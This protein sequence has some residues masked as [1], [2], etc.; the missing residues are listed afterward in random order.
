[1]SAFE[2]VAKFV[3]AVNQLPYYGGDKLEKVVEELFI[4]HNIQDGNNLFTSRFEKPQTRTKGE[5][6][7]LRAHVRREL[8][9]GNFKILADTIPEFKEGLWF[10]NQPMGDGVAYP[11]HLVVLYGRVIYIE[12]KSAQKRAAY[13]YNNTLPH[14]KTFYILSDKT[15]DKT[16]LLQ[17]NNMDMDA[18]EYRFVN[19][20]LKEMKEVLNNLEEKKVRIYEQIYG[21]APNHQP[22]M[23]PQ[24]KHVGDVEQ[25]DFIKRAQE[26]GGE[27]DALQEILRQLKK[28]VSQHLRHK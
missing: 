5:G 1:M 17:A 9:G 4:Q 11:D 25:R 16:S 21:R 10:I 28:G 12:D 3:T 27:V 19:Q 15:H 22:Y 8:R 26:S 18:A 13:R 14:P 7:K 23:R 24:I 2:S 20:W 6:E